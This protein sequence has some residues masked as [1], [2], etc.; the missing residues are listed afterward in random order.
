MERIYTPD[1]LA[2]R[3]RLSPETLAAW[4]KKGTGPR[5]FRAGKHARYRE[6]DVLAWDAAQVEK[7]AAGA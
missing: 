3:Y 6:S 5:Y 4:R 7:Q 2:E 1:E